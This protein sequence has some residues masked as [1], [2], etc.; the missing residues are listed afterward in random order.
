MSWL[1]SCLLESCQPNRAVDPLCLQLTEYVVFCH[2]TSKPDT[3]G[4]ALA[5]RMRA[6]RQSVKTPPCARD[7]RGD[8]VHGQAG[9]NH[10]H[11]GAAGVQLLDVSGPL[12]VFAEANTQVGR[13]IY[14]LRIVASRPG[15]IR[16]SSGVRLMADHVVGDTDMAGPI[17]TLL[18]AGS[19][20][21]PD[22]H[23]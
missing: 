1:V 13:E 15:A 5:E 23:D 16:A 21:A 8:A 19:P 7:E 10:R 6:L 18:V 17:D 11:P 20:Q 4:Q 2:M 12:D 22:M 14:R 9:Q 3:G